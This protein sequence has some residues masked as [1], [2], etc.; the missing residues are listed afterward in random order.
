VLRQITSGR[1][2]RAWAADELFE[3]LNEYEH[4]LA[5]PTRVGQ[6]RRRSPPGITRPRPA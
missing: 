6:P 3:I 1:Y 5:T 2:A 4:H